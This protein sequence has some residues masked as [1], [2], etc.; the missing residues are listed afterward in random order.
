MKLN[1]QSIHHVVNIFFMR[2][3]EYIYFNNNFWK[4]KF[5]FTTYNNYYYKYINIILRFCAILI[6]VIQLNDIGMHINLY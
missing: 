6:Q 2:L 1:Y 4:I 3:V 5:Y